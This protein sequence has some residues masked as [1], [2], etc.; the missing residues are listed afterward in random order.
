MK[1]KT[2]FRKIFLQDSD[3]VRIRMGRIV[4]AEGVRNNELVLSGVQA[5]IEQRIAQSRS[6]MEHAPAPRGSPQA[7]HGLPEDEAEALGVPL[8]ETANTESC[9]V[10]FLLWH[11]GHSA[12]SLPNTNASNS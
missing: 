10:S 1:T 11:L 8:A 4:E 7:P 6:G 9:G 3:S 12:L 5:I 2:R